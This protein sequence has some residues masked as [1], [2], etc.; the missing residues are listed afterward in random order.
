MREL[1]TLALRAANKELKLGANQELVRSSSFMRKAGGGHQE[2]TGRAGVPQE[3]EKGAQGRSRR[4]VATRGQATCYDVYL[5]LHGAFQMERRLAWLSYKSV[6]VTPTYEVFNLVLQVVALLGVVFVVTVEAIVAP[7]VTSLSPH[8]IG[9]FEKP[10]L[11]NLEEDLGPG[12][13]EWGIGE[14][15]DG[16]LEARRPDLDHECLDDQG[17]VRIGD[18]PD[19][20]CEIGKVRAKGLI[21]LLPHPEERHGNRLCPTLARKLAS[22][23]LMSWSKEWMEAS[24]SQSYHPR[25]T[26]HRVVGKAQHIMASD[27]PYKTIYTLN[28]VTC[29]IGS[30]PPSY[31]SSTR[32]WKCCGMGVLDFLDE[33]RATEGALTTL[34]LHPDG[35]SCRLKGDSQTPTG[36]EVGCRQAR[37]PEAIL[38]VVAS[39]LLGLGKLPGA[40]SLAA[41]RAAGCRGRFL[42]AFLLWPGPSC[43]GS[44]NRRQ[45]L[46]GVR[47]G[48]FPSPNKESGGG[49]YGAP[50]EVDY[51]AGGTSSPRLP[52]A[53]RSCDIMPSF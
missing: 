14:P 49:G 42:R 51:V 7:T 53:K 16:L 8:W 47:E 13:V 34:V 11:P 22:N 52:S 30:E 50:P 25:P 12:R 28:A 17:R 46:P 40:V 4:D 41:E 24:G 26:P 44:L 29:S 9:G 33:G 39:P 43:L 36:T 20:F 3:L 15:G 27:V 32:R 6:E 31:A 35:L 18:D 2:A 23:S 10:F 1:W 21:F 45:Y 48:K 5:P 37:S 19:L 38:L